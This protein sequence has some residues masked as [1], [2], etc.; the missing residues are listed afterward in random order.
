M[1]SEESIEGV[2]MLQS[3]CSFFCRSLLSCLVLSW[4]GIDDDFPT[5]LKAGLI[6]YNV[7]PRVGISNCCNTYHKARL[8]VVG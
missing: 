4:Q 7:V 5:S 3:M 8:V 6:K 1:N 2:K